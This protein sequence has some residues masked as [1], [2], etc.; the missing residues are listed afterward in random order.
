[1][2]S[3][4]KKLQLKKLLKKKI[5]SFKCVPVKKWFP[6]DTPQDLIL[7]DRYFTKYRL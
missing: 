3:H 2:K 4:L 1:M 5:K 6:L 7:L